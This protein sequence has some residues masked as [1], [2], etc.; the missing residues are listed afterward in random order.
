MLAV[1]AVAMGLLPAV[2]T[3]TD[4]G[5]AQTYIVLYK[6]TPLAQGQWDGHY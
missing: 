5:T 1:A 2:A 3:A 4:S 6:T